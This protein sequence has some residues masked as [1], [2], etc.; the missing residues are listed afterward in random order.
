MQA[1]QTNRD[2]YIIIINLNTYMQ[3]NTH[4]R[5]VYTNVYGGIYIAHTYLCVCAQPYE[6]I[7][8]S[9][10]CRDVMRTGIIKEN[11]SGLDK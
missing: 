2:I 10:T 3:A 9:I 11:I 4:M 6:Y 5:N 1:P 7:G 8:I